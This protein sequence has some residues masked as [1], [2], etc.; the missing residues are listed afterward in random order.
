ML[1]LVP[2]V[3]VCL[4]A[5]ENVD[6][7]SSEGIIKNE[8]D[9]S[10]SYLG[11]FIFSVPKDVN[12]YFPT[13]F[14]NEYERIESHWNKIYDEADLYDT[15]VLNLLTCSNLSNSQKEFLIDAMNGLKLDEYINFT[16]GCFSK[17]K[18]KTISKDLLTY[19]IFKPVLT[20][21]YFAKYYENAE[22]IKLLSDIKNNDRIKGT[23]IEKSIDSI[24]SGER[25][26]KITKFHKSSSGPMSTDIIDSW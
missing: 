7:S 15:E 25:L 9:P 20:K 10:K 4:K 26:K 2:F 17:Y 12:I 8:C 3:T 13:T 24:L 14:G 11:K 21:N 19:T 22:V 6:E 1:L 23:E 18:K 16:S 5:Q